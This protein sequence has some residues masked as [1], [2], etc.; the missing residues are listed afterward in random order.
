MIS[1]ARGLTAPEWEA[2]M[3][4][5]SGLP[6]LDV[7]REILGR[8]VDMGLVEL[9]AGRPRPTWT[10]REFVELRNSGLFMIVGRSPE[11]VLEG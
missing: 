7:D 6:F 5:A 2:L 10:G 9:V 1:S 4:I 8:L 11:L 3:D